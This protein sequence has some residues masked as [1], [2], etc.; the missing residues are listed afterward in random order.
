VKGCAWSLV[1]ALG[2]FVLAAALITADG[3][4]DRAGPADLIVVP[5]NEVLPDGRPSARLAARLDAALDLFRSGA[6]PQVEA[7]GRAPGTIG[8]RA[9]LG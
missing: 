1:A 6:A 3:L 8:D 9:G 7:R 5:G 2:L 4:V